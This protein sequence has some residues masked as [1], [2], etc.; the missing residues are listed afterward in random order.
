MNKI[1][2][3]FMLFMYGC[4]DVVTGPELKVFPVTQTWSMMNGQGSWKTQKNT[5][6]Q[7]LIDNR[8]TLVTH[9][10]KIYWNSSKGK[11]LADYSEHWLLKA[12]AQP[13]HI[14][15]V[16]GSRFKESLIS[17]VSTHYEVAVPNCSQTQISLT[18]KRP[19]V[20]LGCYTEA[21][22]WKSLVA[23]EDMIAAPIAVYSS[24]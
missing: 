10:V 23:P 15:L 14:S 21:M 13:G 22:R 8:E 6:K 9:P 5:L 3:L 1:L 7:L 11:K 18:P 2:L 17:I 12:G 16:S 4:A 20:E 19:P 24:K